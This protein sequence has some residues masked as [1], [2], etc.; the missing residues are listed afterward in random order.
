[1]TVNDTTNSLTTR[2]IFGNNRKPQSEFHYRNLAEPVE[3]LDKE[4]MDFLKE[5]CP[6]MMEEPH[7]GWKYNNKDEVPFEAH[8]I[9]P[10]FPGYVFDHGNLHIVEKK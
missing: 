2:I 7:Y 6:K 3:S 10:Y 5:A 8:S 4:S 9:L 1:M